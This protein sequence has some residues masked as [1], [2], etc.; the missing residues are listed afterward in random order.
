MPWTT[1]AD[2]KAQLQRLW[3]RGDLP[4]WVVTADASAFP[5]RLPIKG[6]SPSELADQFEAVRTWAGQLQATRAIRL[7]WREIRHRVHGQQSLPAQ[8]WIDSI[9]AALAWIHHERHAARLRQ[10]AADTRAA[11]P[12]VLPWIERRPL[13]ALELAEDWPR[14][15]AVVA[16]VMRH[17]RPGIHLRQIDLPGVHSKFMESHRGVLAEL[18]DM[19]LPA[20]AVQPEATG[21]SRFAARYGFAEK[22]DRIRLRSL[23][24]TLALMPGLPMADITLDATS[25]SQ[26]AP[27]AQRVFITENETN[28]IGLPPAP[29]AIVIF[30]AGYG[31]EALARA[32]WLHRLPL[33]YWGDIDTHG[34]AILHQLRAHFPHAQ[35]L[36]MDHATLMAHQPLWGVEDKPVTADLP[37]LTA[38]EQALYDTLRDNRIRPG[39]RLEQERV[40]YAWVRAA[41]AGA[42]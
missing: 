33:H 37:R 25:F 4:R 10:L 41:V 3:Q 35:S 23:D 28:F 22:P 24:A 26:L 40:G 31:W 5:L 27:A 19:A 42:L 16:W 18:L 34:F 2:L 12:A 13:Q 7:D 29:G 1:P 21:A 38:E 9:D 8:A 15:L 32:T 20:S 11:V 30:G 6:P 36:L 14:L 39:L 17:P